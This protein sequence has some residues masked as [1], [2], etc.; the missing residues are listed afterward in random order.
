ME[1]HKEIVRLDIYSPLQELKNPLFEEKEVRVFIKRDDLIHPFIS[2]NKWRKL[3][4]TLTRARE[5]QKEHLITFGGAYS[6]HLVATACAAAKFGFRSTGFV[7]GEVVKNHALML[8]RMFGM[9]LIFTNRQSYRN[10]HELFDQ[11]FKNDP[12]AFFINEGGSGEEAVK[13]CAELI[14]EL[15]R[16]FDH[17]FCAAG[18]GATAAGL[19]RG[20]TNNNYPVV[21]H[22]VSSLKDGFFLKDEIMKYG[23]NA[24][25]LTVHCDYHFGGYAKTT[26]EL[27]GFISK[28][29]AS[30][31]ILL[32]QVYTGKAAYA[33]FDLLNKN[34]IERGSKIVLIHTGGVLGM[35]SQVENF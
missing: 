7:R 21:L 12:E 15:D 4:Y 13:G 23:S 30:T 17:I 22:A 14:K 10:K 27:L 33:M 31:G 2:G 25:N 20:I 8:C 24:N 5:R 35:L 1:V 11:H 3:K 32:D 28:F 18:T 19:L 6:N 9:D 29:A 26:P 16:V 34:Q